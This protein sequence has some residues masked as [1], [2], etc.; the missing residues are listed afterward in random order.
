[1]SA[2][3]DKEVPSLSADLTERE[4]PKATE[5]KAENCPLSD[6]S[7]AER[8]ESDTILPVTD[9]HDSVLSAPETEREPVKE[10]ELE[11]TERV[12]EIAS[13]ELR[14]KDSSNTAGE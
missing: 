8:D 9:R 11:H 7:E 6:R 1:M 5:P 12:P 13:Q 2:E 3:A 4:L 14:D 10:R